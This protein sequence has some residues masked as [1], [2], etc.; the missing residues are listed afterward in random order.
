MRRRSSS[1]R[2]VVD[3]A[4]VGRDATNV[5]AAQGLG[6]HG[7]PDGTGRHRADYDEEEHR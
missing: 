2:G 1:H 6:W 7:I 4:R 5:E 3:W